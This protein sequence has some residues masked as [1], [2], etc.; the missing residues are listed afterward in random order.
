MPA[1]PEIEIVRRDLEKEIVGR[2]IKDVDIRPGTNAMKIIRRHGRRKEFQDLLTGAKVEKVDR[3]GDRLLLRLDNAHV[4]LFDL[5]DSAS[6]LKTSAS[7]EMAAHT[8]IV[9][10]FTI[11]GQLR[12]VDPS[13]L[14]EVFVVRDEDLDSVDGLRRFQM[15]PLESPIAWPH[16]SALLETHDVPVRDLLLDE[17]FIIGLREIYTDEILFTA[18]IRY[19]RPSNKLGSQ[20]V[21]RLYRALMETLQEAMKLRGT[22]IGEQPFRDL[23]GQPGAYQIELKVYERDGESCRRCRNTVVKEKVKGGFTYLCPQCQT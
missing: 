4:L 8:H 13:R 10:G 12:F 7:D 18:G 11:G 23:Q 22:S 3:I 1:L 19:D 21:R 15:D 14:G 16:L 2:R 5:A 9:I 17:S 6:L 20:D